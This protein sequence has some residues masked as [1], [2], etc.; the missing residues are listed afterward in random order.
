MKHGVG[1]ANE[2]AFK[3]VLSKLQ[4]FRSIDSNSVKD[5]PKDPKDAPKKVRCCC[6]CCSCSFENYKQGKRISG[7]PLPVASLL[8]L[9]KCERVCV[10]MAACGS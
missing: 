9:C 7:N 1:L 10:S 2:I 3:V 8:S 4:I 6:S 5:F